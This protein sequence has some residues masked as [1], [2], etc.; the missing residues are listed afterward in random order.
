M[1]TSVIA[2]AARLE[3]LTAGFL[4]EHRPHGLAGVAAGVVRDGEL[5]WSAG[6]GLAD[7]AAGRAP[8]ETT[9]LRIA[10]I[11][12]TFTGTA[13]M[14]LAAGG[15]LHPDDPAVRHLP[16][17]RAI[18]SP[19]GPA[20]TLTIR[21]LLSHESGLQGE[22][23][24]TDW[25]VP[26]YEGRADRNLARA[27]E[28]GLRVPPNSQTKYSNLGYQL[29]G[30]IV[31]RVSG[32]P[33][34]DY[35]RQAIL[36]PLGLSSTGFGPLP[37]DLTGRCATGYQREPYTDVLVPAAVTPPVQAEGGLWSSVA[38]LARWLSFQLSAYPAGGEGQ[39]SA[40]A[41][42][43]AGA[44][45][46]VLPAALLRAMHTPRY[47]AD[48]DWSRAFGIS[49]FATRKDG[50]VWIQH[51]G[52]LPGFTSTVCFDRERPLGA[53]VL[54]NGIAPTSELAFALAA[55]A[56]EEL[57]GRPAPGQAA[58]VP[59]AFRPLLGLYA[60][61]ELGVTLRLEWR[62]GTL[63]LTDP[64]VPSYRPEL[65]PAGGQDTYTVGPGFRESGEQAVFRRRADGQVTGMFLAAMTMTRLDTV[66]AE[67]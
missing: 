34:P 33:Y 65:T 53:I 51:D 57:P 47:L 64:E 21:R 24:G 26:A 60:A 49:W 36:E 42:E 55:A 38:D 1:A 5:A 10:S 16:E 62:D 12:K 3:E 66:P 44:E 27:A 14:Q 31:A 50:V 43:P 56:G 61:P 39:G 11:T 17:L 19:F 40:G 58:P 15:G 46:K 9:L 48:P 59:A 20:E 25:A 23:P 13:I 29:L 4:R 32:T 67:R 2:S 63:V 8:D 28:V 22:P 37:A 30:E 18:A 41:A 7:V 52:G 35:L 45:P 6:C 54:A